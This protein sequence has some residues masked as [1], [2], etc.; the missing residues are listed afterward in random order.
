MCYSCTNSYGKEEAW[1]RFQKQCIKDW[2]FEW[3]KEERGYYLPQHIADKIGP[4]KV[5]E[6]FD[7][8]HNIITLW[9]NLRDRYQPVADK[10]HFIK[11]KLLDL[12][13]DEL[14]AELLQCYYDLTQIEERSIDKSVPIT[15]ENSEEAKILD[16]GYAFSLVSS[17]DNDE[18]ER[19]R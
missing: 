8:L 4:V 18:T 12:G 3:D 1:W 9:Q 16:I 7:E 11:N 14:A 10:I 15:L 6:R 5:K 2:D 17:D 13:H 19:A